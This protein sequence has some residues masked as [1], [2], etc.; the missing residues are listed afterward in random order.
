MAL[1]ESEVDRI[2]NEDSFE[3]ESDID[4]GSGSEYSDNVLS[5]S[6]SDS[7]EPSS[8][9][10]S[11]D[12]G[13]S[14][15][16]KRK[17]RKKLTVTPNCK[18]EQSLQQSVTASISI[19]RN[20]PAESTV[21]FQASYRHEESAVIEQLDTPSIN[22]NLSTSSTKSVLVEYSQEKAKETKTLSNKSRKKTAKEIV[23]TKKI[24]KQSTNK[25]LLCKQ[26]EGNPKKKKKSEKPIKVKPTAEKKDVDIGNYDANFESVA[27]DIDQNPEEDHDEVEDI[28]DNDTCARTRKNIVTWRGIDGCRWNTELP[29][30][31]TRTSARNI[32]T[33]SRG[34]RGNARL[35]Q[36]PLEAFSLFISDEMINMIVEYTNIEI[37]KNRQKYSVITSTIAN[38]DAIEL[39]AL[40]G[41]LIFSAFHK[42]NHLSTKAMFDSNQS[43]SIYKATFSKERFEFLIDSLRFDDKTTRQERRK[44]DKFAPIRELWDKFISHCKEYYEV[45]TYVTIDEQL[46]AFRGRC[47]FKMYM[48]KKPA[49]YGLKIMMVCDVETKYMVNAAPYTGKG[50]TPRN[51]SVA[52]YFVKTLTEPLHGSNRNV[53]MDNWFTSVPL[54]NNLLL[55]PYKLT[56][57]G[58]IRRNKKELPSQI[59]KNTRKRPIGDVKFC[60]SGHKVLLSYKA[61][62]NKVVCLLSTMHQDA[63]ISPSGKPTMIEHYN[64]TKG[65]V[66]AFDQMCSIFSASRR[67]KRWPMCVFY[68]IINMSCINALVIHNTNLV[69]KKNRPI[70]RK[71]FMH[72]LY[73]ALIFPWLEVRLQRPTLQRSLKSMISEVLGKN[74]EPEVVQNNP[75]RRGVCSICPS[76]KRRM[77]TNYCVQCK[78][79]FCGEHR[80]MLCVKCVKL[81]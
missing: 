1:R 26:T 8:D 63:T 52:E 4:C 37:C 73:K 6:G 79:P 12:S 3:A 74:D 66:D 11:A 50:S 5:Y 31:N 34:N 39:K 53:T 76:K 9:P 17:G 56:I 35:V 65:G 2:M 19:C 42:D 24:P 40:L 51:V 22:E 14:E 61:K 46:L 67:T 25:R 32:V 54:A 41:L 78:R 47:P 77:T 10:E 57:L 18:I 58:T 29:P 59:T 48:P 13:Q 69:D 80:A 16:K 36:S 44:D 75:N 68:G 62:P 33:K 49:K 45:G 28:E 72:E 21:D 70:S 60:F 23:A 30:A 38:T 64:Q 15:K 43:G 27:V 55:P 7:Y 20:L 81:E 71:D